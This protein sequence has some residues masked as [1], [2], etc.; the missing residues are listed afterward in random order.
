ME[1]RFSIS[2]TCFLGWK[3]IQTWPDDV[4]QI[5]PRRLRA[6]QNGQQAEQQQIDHQNPS[7]ARQQAFLV[8]F[9]PYPSLERVVD[10]GRMLQVLQRDIAAAAQTARVRGI[11]RIALDLEDLAVLD[12]S[13]NAAILVTEIAAGLLHFDAGSV[14]TDV[15]HL[16]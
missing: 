5:G 16:P 9:H 11:I 13:E 2:W 1:I 4:L 15:R 8:W 3:Y 12:V 10:A 6:H 14:D 7:Q